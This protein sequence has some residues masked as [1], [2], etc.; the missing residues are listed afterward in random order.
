MK[1][2]WGEWGE[3]NDCTVTCG[4]GSQERTR[5]CDNPQPS[6]GGDHCNVDGSLG[7]HTKLCNKSPCSGYIYQTKYNKKRNSF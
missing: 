2:S 5:V 1:G 6:H 7:I 4:G 3:W